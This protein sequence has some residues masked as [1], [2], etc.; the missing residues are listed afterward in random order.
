MH[1]EARA[2]LDAIDVGAREREQ[3]LAA[4]RQAA[5]AGRLREAYGLALADA[6]PGPAGEEGRLFAQELRARMDMV[7][8]GLDQVRATLH[9]RTSGG[10]AGLRHCLLRVDELA[11]VQIDHE[12]IPRLRAALLAETAGIDTAEQAVAAL[13][14]G[15]FQVV[16]DAIG[17]L[18]AQREQLL[19][20]DRLDARV[21]DLADR[22]QAA[23][24]SALAAG[25]LAECERC[26]VGV[27]RAALVRPGHQEVVDRISSAAAQRRA[28]AEAL[29]AEAARL[30]AAR[31]LTAAEQRCEAAR[32]LW[33]D[34]SAVRKVEEE[35]QS[36]R[37]QQARLQRVEAMAAGGDVEGAHAELGDMPPT[38]AMLRTR[39]FDMK[40]N[41]ARAQGLDGAFLLRVDEGGEFLTLR[42]ESLTIGNLRD[43]RADL[44]I[45]AAIA[46]R[47]ARIQRSMSFHGGMQDSI[48][49]EGGELRVGGQRVANHGLRAGERV[50]LGSALQIA[51]DQPSKR[52]LTSSLQLLGGFQVAGT[53]RVLLFKDRGR[54]GRILIGAGSDVHVRVP[55]A[56]G[57]VEI[58][59]NK[60]GQMRVRAEG[61]G[62]IDGRPFRDEHPVDAG[63][64]VKAAGVTFVMMPWV[65]PS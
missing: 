16:A 37:Q 50:Q 54:D 28:D 11:K 1:D 44:P 60:G 46:G 43:G 8:R 45:L 23:A 10:V 27:A 18:V 29:A 48:V 52:S 55:G 19:Q 32:Q 17:T 24:E 3:R 9:G 61:G 59:A 65:R 2:E 7:G 58:F 12:D 31:E 20:P 25:R 4:A 38:P 26:L 6:L 21:L 51:Y 64:T 33:V 15:Q 40:Q 63:A 41:L 39:I 57:E 62:E 22:L 35:L 53:D 49:A 30:L 56:K 36:L 5:K 34:G 47:H 14:K 13:G 42:G